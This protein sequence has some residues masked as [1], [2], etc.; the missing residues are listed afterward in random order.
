MRTLRLASWED[1]TVT[2]AVTKRMLMHGFL[3]PYNKGSVATS[4]CTSTI[5]S[6]GRKL[7]QSLHNAFWRM[8]RMV[9]SALARTGM[10]VIIYSMCWI[11]SCEGN[12]RGKRSVGEHQ[13]MHDRG[14]FLQEWKR[15][16]WLKEVM[17]ELHTA[18]E[19]HP[20][21]EGV[22]KPLGQ[23]EP[24][25]LPRTPRYW[26]TRSSIVPGDVRGLEEGDLSGLHR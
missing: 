22:E 24:S 13:E 5:A 16:Q 15:Q 25:P 19:V 3:I 8:E 4:R 10:I 11:L 17:E 14:R 2:S 6:W 9:S 12:P 7:F 21:D 26:E 1:I 23:R 20:H 18:V